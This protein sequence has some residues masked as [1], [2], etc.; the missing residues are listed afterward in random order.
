MGGFCLYFFGYFEYNR[1]FVLDLYLVLRLWRGSVSVG[2]IFG[3]ILVVGAVLVVCCRV[4]WKVVF[5][6]C[7]F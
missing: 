6:F 1:I 2:F 4:L 7:Y 5:G 3:W